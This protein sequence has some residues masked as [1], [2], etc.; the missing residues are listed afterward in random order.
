MAYLKQ[1]ILFLFVISILVN[2]GM[3]VFADDE[4]TVEQWQLTRLFSPTENDLQNE[5]NGK[6][7]IY[8]GLKDIDVDHA[9]DKNFNRI[10]SMMFIKTIVTDSDGEPEIDKAT[11]MTIA[12]YDDGCD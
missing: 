8:S 6:V 3:S 11:N 9:L 5:A 10:Q 12:E 1:S 7:F 2:P 4:N